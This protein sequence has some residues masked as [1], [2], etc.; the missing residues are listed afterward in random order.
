METLV[1]EFS[2][3]PVIVQGALGSALFWLISQILIA[4][5][6]AFDRARG[7]LGKRYQRD[8][9]MREWIYRKYTSRSG[10][11]N[12][13]QGYAVTFDHVGRLVIQ[14]LIYISVSLLFSTFLPVVPGIMGVA[15]LYYFFRAYVWLTP[16]H[17]WSNDSVV[18]NWER[19]AQLETAFYG[20]PDSDTTAQ[21]EKLR[22]ESGAAMPG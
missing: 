5:W 16:S 1:S 14:G 21:L 12:I 13:V 9:D 17:T 7:R 2:N 15:A 18:S 3:W 11:S 20:K 4:T 6:K 22:T 10:L 8:R 19:I